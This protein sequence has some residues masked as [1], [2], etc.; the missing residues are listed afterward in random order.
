M[1]LAILPM[2]AGQMTSTFAS[3]LALVALAMVLSP[4]AR[5]AHRVRAHIADLLSMGIVTIALCVTTSPGHAGMPMPMVGVGGI[6]IA[7]LVAIAWAGVRSAL[8]VQDTRHRRWSIVTAS[9]TAA[10]LAA[11]F[12]L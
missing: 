8:A 7:V 2:L 3:G 12:V 1:I 9:L 5:A 4:F 6:P 10:C 11:M